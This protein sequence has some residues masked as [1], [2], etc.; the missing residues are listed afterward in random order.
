MKHRNQFSL[1]CFISNF[2]NSKNVKSHTLN[3][4]KR[5]LLFIFLLRKSSKLYM[6]FLHLF[7]LYTYIFTHTL[8]ICKLRSFYN[9]KYLIL[10][11][12][13]K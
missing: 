12:L 13:N 3:E 11:Y 8:T 1:N 5:N 9:I 6:L 4:N 2:K 7:L 10:F